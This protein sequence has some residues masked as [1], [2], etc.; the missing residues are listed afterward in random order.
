MGQVPVLVVEKGGK[1]H[2]VC[3]SKAV[4]RYVAGQL[5]L[6]G[7]TPEEAADI[8]SLVETVY[9][10]IVPAN[11]NAKTPEDRAKFLAEVLP[12]HLATL[13]ALVGDKLYV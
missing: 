6:L 7:A 8:D 4:G 5:G 9:G 10:D 12:K 2:R 11:N 1:T 3:Q 13:E